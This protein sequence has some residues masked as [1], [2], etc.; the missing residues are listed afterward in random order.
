MTVHNIEVNTYIKIPMR[1]ARYGPFQPLF[2]RPRRIKPVSYREDK[3]IF[4]HFFCYTSPKADYAR[5]TSILLYTEYNYGF[6]YNITY[7]L[8]VFIVLVTVEMIFI[9]VI[10]K[11]P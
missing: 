6:R 5:I 8:Y 9:I 4:R 10:R 7:T 11:C 3:I 1:F 2:I